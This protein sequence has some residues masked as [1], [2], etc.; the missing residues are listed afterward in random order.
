[1]E[2]SGTPNEDFYL[3]LLSNAST[4]EFPNNKANSFQNILPR[5]INLQ[6]DWKAGL[7]SVSLP[8]SSLFHLKLNPFEQDLFRIGY[9]R[10]TVGASQPSNL[11]HSLYSHAKLQELSPDV[12]GVEFM[13]S[14]TNFFDQDRIDG[15]VGINAEK[16]SQTNSAGQEESLFWK[17]K[18]E[19]EELVTDN[20]NIYRGDRSYLRAIHPYFYI[21][22]DLAKKMGWITKDSRGMYHLG[23][24]LKQEFFNPYLVPNL[25]AVR[26]PG[27]IYENNSNSPNYR[28]NVF[29]TGDDTYY[30]PEDHGNMMRLSYWC[31]W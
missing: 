14:V 5:Q 30:G 11:E 16:F 21:E 3:T 18:W 12:N 29:F 25:Q 24:N 31:N 9:M 6:G 28:K 27:D 10:T 1:M 23:P 8:D 2:T 17:F 13:K 26:D 15:L 22:K 4:L 20:K 19:G 7:S